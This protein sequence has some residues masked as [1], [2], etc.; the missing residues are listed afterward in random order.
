MDQ[1][2]RRPLSGSTTVVVHPLVLLSVVDHYNRCGAPCFGNRRA[3][4]PSITCA[5][6]GGLRRA[7]KG[8]TNRAVGVLLGS[9][10]NNN[11]L[12]IAN[13]FAGAPCLAWQAVGG[14]EGDY[15][16]RTAQSIPSQPIPDAAWCVGV[17]VWVWVDSTF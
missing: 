15:L 13:S 9:W 16:L 8:T 7:C 5:S 12:D 3:R 17:G 4:G 11:T 1:V 6:W 14:W 10:K 2:A